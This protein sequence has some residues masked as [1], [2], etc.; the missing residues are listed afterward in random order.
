MSDTECSHGWGVLDSNITACCDGVQD[1]Q[2][3]KKG[4]KKKRKGKKGDEMMLQE[5]SSPAGSALTDTQVSSP[6][7]SSQNTG[8]RPDEL[9]EEAL[10]EVEAPS[11]PDM[12]ISQKKLST[13][14][15]AG[16][17][18]SDAQTVATKAIA[19]PGATEATAAGA[20]DSA[21]LT[22]INDD[23]SAAL[24]SKKLLK[25]ESTKVPPSPQRNHVKGPGRRAAHGSPAGNSSNKSEWVPVPGQ[26]DPLEHKAEWQ[27][28]G[29]RKAKRAT[30]GKPTDSGTNTAQQAPEAAPAHQPKLPKPQKAGKG[31]QPEAQGGHSKGVDPTAKMMPAPGRS[32]GREEQTG[33]RQPS[34]AA[35]KGKASARKAGKAGAAEGKHTSSTKAARVA[36]V[37]PEQQSRSTKLAETKAPTCPAMSFA[38]MARPARAPQA[39]T[40]DLPAPAGASGGPVPAQKGRP[41]QSAAPQTRAVQ[42]NH[43]YVASPFMPTPIPAPASQ[44]V[45]SNPAQ[46]GTPSAHTAIPAAH[47]SITAEAAPAPG[48]GRPS[49]HRTGLPGPWQAVQGQ[50]VQDPQAAA[51]NRQHAQPVSSVPPSGSPAGK[52]WPLSCM[53][54][55]L[56]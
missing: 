26:P 21:S 14:E 9:S 6:E 7:E 52:Y 4:K 30:G 15:Q 33:P 40:A 29:G 24:P 36:P 17:N 54:H 35:A 53:I 27:A 39:G 51:S 42:G 1:A 48:P 32:S 12:Q 19:S 41:V 13:A 50:P 49:R 28:A 45:Q 31:V 18:V 34:Q 22:Q 37:I 16:K 5:K 56:P 3:A 47:A 46:S 8:L 55:A 25:D 11:K 2:E 38:D 10:P 44:Q 43:T 20:S 23:V